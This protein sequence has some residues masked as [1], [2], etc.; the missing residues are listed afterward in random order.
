MIIVDIL[1]NIDSQQKAM[2]THLLKVAVHALVLQLNL[3]VLD[4]LPSRQPVKAKHRHG[5]KPVG[6]RVGL[7]R[8]LPQL[9]RHSL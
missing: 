8:V 7:A 4:L 2:L 1:D 9:A 3:F 6:V 5:A